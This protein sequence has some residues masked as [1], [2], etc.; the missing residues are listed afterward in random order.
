M[1]RCECI[2]SRV[3]LCINAADA[4]ACGCLHVIATVTA[5]IVLCEWHCGT[6]QASWYPVT[7][8]GIVHL[9]ISQVSAG[10]TQSVAW[11]W[12]PPTP[13]ATCPCPLRHGGSRLLCCD[14]TYCLYHMNSLYLVV[15]LLRAGYGGVPAVQPVS[16][17]RPDDACAVVQLPGAKARRQVVPVRREV[18]RRAAP[19]LTLRHVSWLRILPS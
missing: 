7:A 1:W 8:C 15:G 9:I 3:Q 16:G 18:R 12:P 14:H 13:H 2:G 11:C 4:A 17:Q 19:E 6:S 5:R 10:R